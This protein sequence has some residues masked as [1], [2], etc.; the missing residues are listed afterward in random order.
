MTI[1]L[2][3][4][5]KQQVESFN[6]LVSMPATEV[7]RLIASFPVSSYDYASLSR[8]E[9]ENLNVFCHL[10][11][12]H[13][14]I[15]PFA[16]LDRTGQ[17]CVKGLSR[18][19]DLSR[20]ELPG[21]LGIGRSLADRGLDLGNW[22]SSVISYFNWN[23]VNTTEIGLLKATEDAE[24]AKREKAKAS[25]GDKYVIPAHIQRSLFVPGLFGN[26]LPTRSTVLIRVT[27]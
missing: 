27:D 25:G 12:S 16:I 21:T 24:V 5:E 18:P 13:I 17:R 1:T 4:Y 9:L 14:S 20:V 26:K 6:K 3:R 7:D 15:A 8:S 19:N 2:T 23:T 22:N 10:D 11:G